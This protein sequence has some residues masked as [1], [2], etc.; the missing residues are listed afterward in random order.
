MTFS[1]Q[2]SAAQAH[3]ENI[4]LLEMMEDLNRKDLFEATQDL[5]QYWKSRL[6]ITWNFMELRLRSILCRK[7]DLNLGL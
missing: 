4:G 2:N 6:R 3:V 1:W 7:T 5:A